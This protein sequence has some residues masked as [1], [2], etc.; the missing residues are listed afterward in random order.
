[1]AIGTITVVSKNGGQPSAP[2]FVDEISF[3]PGVYATGGLDFLAAFQAKVASGR[4]PLLV[5][6]QNSGY[7]AGYDAASGKLYL[8]HSDNDAGA[9]SALIEANGV[10]FGTLVF[11]VLSR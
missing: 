5:E 9:D 2:L 1:M 8:Y 6:L 7:K 10:T 4:V 3:A 11:V